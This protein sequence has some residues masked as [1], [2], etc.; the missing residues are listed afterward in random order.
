MKS[1][2]RR[3]KE[4]V[5]LKYSARRR[6]DST[7]QEVSWFVVIKIF[8]LFSHP[9]WAFGHHCGTGKMGHKEKQRQQYFRYHDL[10]EV[11]GTG[12]AVFGLRA[13]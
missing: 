3:L 7:N 6:Y 8:F 13:L 1:V 11:S 2:T 12:T 5:W 9:Q 4:N 10:P